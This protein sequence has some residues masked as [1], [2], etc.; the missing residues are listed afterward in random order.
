MDGTII[1]AGRKVTIGLDD[2]MVI[3]VE[4][5]TFVLADIE[6]DRL[7]GASAARADG[8][9]DKTETQVAGTGKL[10]HICEMTCPAKAVR[11]VPD[12]GRK[13]VEDIGTCI[14][15]GFC[16]VPHLIFGIV[17]CVRHKRNIG[18]SAPAAGYRQQNGKHCKGHVS[19]RGRAIREHTFRR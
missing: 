11:P 14:A 1:S 17:R 12:T 16:P 3:E 10:I 7:L 2:G 9:K 6:E 8:K 5:G 15:N 13:D 19:G 4:Y 18:Y